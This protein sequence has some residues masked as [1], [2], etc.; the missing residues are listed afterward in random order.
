M[1]S[2]S[3]R[4]VRCLTVGERRERLHRN[5]LISLKVFLGTERSNAPFPRPLNL[6]DSDLDCGLERLT[7]STVKE[8]RDRSRIEITFLFS[9]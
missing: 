8:D 1:D 9:S 5:L 4:V 7:Q 3:G 2:L 6:P